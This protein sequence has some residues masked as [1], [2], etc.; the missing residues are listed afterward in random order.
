MCVLTLSSEALGR[1]LE[2]MV[3]DFRKS[4]M[5]DFW[6]GDTKVR[7]GI[8]MASVSEICEVLWLC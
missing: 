6:F 7:I 4:R 3:M 2:K 1:G 5:I 8:P